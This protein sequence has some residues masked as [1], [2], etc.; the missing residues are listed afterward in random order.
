MKRVEI[1]LENVNLKR[2]RRKI[3]KEMKKMGASE[4][5]IKLL[6]D[7]TVCNNYKRKRDPKDVAWA[8]LQ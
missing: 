3:E 1:V 6:K 4:L 7:E 2:Y 5:E 8:I